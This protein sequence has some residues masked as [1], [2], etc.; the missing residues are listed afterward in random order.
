SC[1]NF[2]HREKVRRRAHRQA[3]NRGDGRRARLRRAQWRMLNRVT[4]ALHPAPAALAQAPLLDRA[5]CELNVTLAPLSSLAWCD[6]KV[7]A[8]CLQ[9]VG[10][11]RSDAKY[12]AAAKP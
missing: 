5:N 4:P 3:V 12:L 11:Q 9:A 7:V 8:N 2:C 6:R 1:H 10:L